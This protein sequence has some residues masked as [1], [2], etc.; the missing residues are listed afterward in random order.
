MRLW[1]ATKKYVVSLEFHDISNVCFCL[2]GAW[3]STCRQSCGVGFVRSRRFLGGVGVG[4][5]TTLGVGVRFVCPTPTPDVQLDHC[6][7]HALKLGIPV[8]IV[9]FLLKLLLKQISCCA[10]GFPLILTVKFHSLY[11]K[12]SGVGNFGMAGV[13]VGNFVKSESGVGVGNFGKVGVGVGVGYFTS[14]SATLHVGLFAEY[15]VLWI[16]HN[17]KQPLKKVA[18]LKTPF[19][20]LLQLAWKSGKKLTCKS[21]RLL[22]MSNSQSRLREPHAAA[23]HHLRGSQQPVTKT[24]NILCNWLRSTI[25]QNV[26][27]DLC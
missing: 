14:D 27:V 12:E 4:F 22:T 3:S 2:P 19:V 10:P 17:A 21:S 7:D 13:G 9:Q 5:L 6:L 11:G 24:S 16:V 26:S 1:I 18:R 8:E 23:N 15:Y 25:K 20:K